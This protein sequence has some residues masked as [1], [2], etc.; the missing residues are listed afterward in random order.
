MTN[1]EDRIENDGQENQTDDNLTTKEAE[2]TKPVSQETGGDQK[3]DSLPEG[4]TDAPQDKEHM[5]L[6]LIKDSPSLVDV[7]LKVSDDKGELLGDESLEEQVKRYCELY[8]ASK[9]KKTEDP[10]RILQEVKD[11]S[12]CYSK[13]INKSFSI[14][15]GADT[16][17]RIRLGMLFN[18]QKKLVRM[19]RQNW[20]EW[21]AQNYGKKYLRSVQDYMSL[22]RIPNVIRYAVFGKERLMELKR[23]IQ[24]GGKDDDPIGTFLKSHNALFDPESADPIDK[25][26]QEVDAALAMSKIHGVEQERD[27]ELGVRF[28]LIKKLVG[29]G[30]K[31]DI[32]IIND[33]VIIKENGRDVNQYIEDRY[34]DGGKEEDIIVSAKKVRG[35]PKSVAVIKDTVDYFKEHSDLADQIEMSQIST[36]EESIAALKAL[37]NNS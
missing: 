18:F 3:P 5:D 32:G 31:T 35:F 25:F 30:I 8:Q 20:G 27:T 24:M 29:L 26:K 37:M 16:K 36:L 4:V 2:K 33:L 17:Y 19:T 10:D 1:K 15:D 22:A 13:Q 21:F 12:L 6:G 34:M 9:K 11:L 14:G 28:D 23:A 7:Y